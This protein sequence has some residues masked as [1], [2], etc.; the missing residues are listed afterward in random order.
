MPHTP[1]P[2]TVV[3]ILSLYGVI[4]NAYDTGL[5]VTDT[6]TLDHYWEFGW[7]HGMSIGITI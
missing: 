7:V 3:P 5:P 1:S 4:F 6:V 2:F